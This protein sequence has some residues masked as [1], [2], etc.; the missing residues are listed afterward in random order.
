MLIYKYM[1][2]EDTQLKKDQL[3]ECPFIKD[4]TLLN[5]E[6]NQLYF[7]GAYEFND[8]FDS[9]VRGYF[10]GTKEQMIKY[11]KENSR[12]YSKKDDDLI[13]SLDGDY[14]LVDEFET[15]VILE[16]IKLPLTCCFSEINNSILMWSHYA[17]Y[18]R[19]ICL[20]FK[21]EENHGSLES[22]Y[23]FN[24]NSEPIQM[25]QVT[26]DRTK[27]NPKCV[28]FLDEEHHKQVAQFFTKKLECWFYEKEHRIIL[29]EPYAT[30]IN[31]F[32]KKDLESVIFGCNI[33]YE[34]AS[35]VRRI[36]EDK[37]LQEGYSVKFCKTVL[38]IDEIPILEIDDIDK[39]LSS[40]KDREYTI[41]KYRN[42]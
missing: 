36:I 27:D 33:K 26:Y 19:G 28:N 13:N 18:H 22:K 37:Y 25:Y 2:L 24:L 12:D 42:Q 6:N 14:V 5:L 39:Y 3:K 7:S 11:F 38:D 34:N 1:P 21:V 9:K 17:N 35:R 16:L 40:L 41:S 8:P 32:D 29:L 23:L 4:Y 30:N 10:K 15:E 31:K 20:G